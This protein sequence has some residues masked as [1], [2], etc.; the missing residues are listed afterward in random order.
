M[1]WI[2][3]EC[4]WFGSLYHVFMVGDSAG[5][6]LTSQY[7]AM[8]HNL[9]YMSHFH[10]PHPGIFLKAIGLNCGM[11]DMS[12]QAAEK[13]SGIHLDYLGKHLPADDPRFRA[14]ES[15]GSN[16]PPAHITT[17]CHDFLR[18]CAQPMHRLLTEKGIESQWKC[19]GTEENETVGHVFHV[20]ILLPDAVQ[21]ND[22]AAARSLDGQ[23]AAFGKVTSGM[24]V[25]DEIAATKTGFQDRPVAEQKIASITVDTKGEIYPEPNKLPDPY[26]RF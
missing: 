13:R 15:I 5:A 16:Y 1:H 24:D 9:E 11:Y 21:C 4:Q 22:D 17:A 19:Y 23:Y 12:I 8:L 18:E 6:Q 2:S 7:A 10:F 25:V 14:L 20:N 3:K 26:G